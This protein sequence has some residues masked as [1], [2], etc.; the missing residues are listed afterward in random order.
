MKL[1]TLVSQVSEVAKE[2]TNGIRRLTKH[3]HTTATEIKRGGGG[4]G[5]EADRKDEFGKVVLFGQRG[6]SRRHVIPD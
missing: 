4:R 5:P 1:R 6:A 2:D 3:K